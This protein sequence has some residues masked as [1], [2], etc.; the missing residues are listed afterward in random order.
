M[1]KIM[2]NLKKNKTVIVFD[3]DGVLG[4]YEYSDKNHAIDVP[5]EEWDEYVKKF[6]PLEDENRIRPFKTIQKFLKEKDMSRIYVCSVASG[7]AEKV[8]KSKFAMKHYNIPKENIYFVPSKK[9][10]LNLLKYLHESKYP[11]LEESEIAMVEDTVATLNQI[12]NNSDFMTVHI[13]SFMD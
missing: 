8:A 7:E 3:F 1:N 9:E 12:F 10:K 6:N 5:D 4:S 2:E 13:T 11:N